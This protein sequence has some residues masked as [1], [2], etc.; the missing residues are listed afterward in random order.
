MASQNTGGCY[1]KGTGTGRGQHAATNRALNRVVHPHNT[2]CRAK[3]TIH[4]KRRAS[5]VIGTYGGAAMTET[6]KAA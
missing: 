5:H 1:T 2:L 3:A 4:C 6:D